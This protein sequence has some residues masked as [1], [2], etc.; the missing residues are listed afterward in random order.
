MLLEL[1]VGL[2]ALVA[3]RMRRAIVVEWAAKQG[4]SS[5]L[6][7]SHVQCHVGP[8]RDPVAH[9]ERTRVQ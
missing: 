5:A 4:C 7:R 2:H 6:G 8:S 1:G 9:L 3:H